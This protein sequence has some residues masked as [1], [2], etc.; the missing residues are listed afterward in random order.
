MPASLEAS[1]TGC[2]TFAAIKFAGYSLFAAGLRRVYRSPAHPLTVGA[3]RTVLGMAVGAA[4]WAVWHAFS[5]A[6][7]FS[8]GYLIGLAPLRIGEW[9]LLL[10]LFHDRDLRH[11]SRG[12][13]AVGLGTVWSYL[14]DL[15]AVLGFLLTGGLSIC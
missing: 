13:T 2:L 14:C 5:P 10:W 12:W 1:V 4:Y 3:A 8:A 7:T 6:Q 11:R 9:W 15:P